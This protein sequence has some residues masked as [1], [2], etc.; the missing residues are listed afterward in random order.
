MAYGGS[1]RPTG[2]PWTINSES[3]A[4]LPCSPGGDIKIYYAAVSTLLVGDIVFCSGFSSGS[5]G[6]QPQVNKSST[7]ANYTASAMG[8]VMGGDNTNMSVLGPPMSSGIDAI[9]TSFIGYPACTVIN[10]RVLVCVYGVAFVTS[11]VAI[12]ASSRVTASAVTAGYIT[13]VGYAAGS[14]IGQTLDAF[15]GNGSIGRIL[16]SI[17]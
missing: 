3:G 12:A 7:L 4:E 10:E 8:V 6:V 9:D 16:V 2:L 17:C 14:Q 13:T 5:V 1:H 11:G 15:A